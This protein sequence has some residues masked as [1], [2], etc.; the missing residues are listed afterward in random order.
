M[1]QNSSE[2]KTKVSA[3]LLEAYFSLRGDCESPKSTEVLRKCL[4]F[5]KRQANQEMYTAPEKELQFYNDFVAEYSYFVTSFSDNSDQQIVQTV[6]GNITQTLSDL[7][8]AYVE[9]VRGEQK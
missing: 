3:Q 9:G 2:Y 5:L 1:A 6:L 8:R 7:T 4:Q